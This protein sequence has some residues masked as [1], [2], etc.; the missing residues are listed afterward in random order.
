MEWS[1]LEGVPI[2]ER[3][4]VLANARRR[5]FRYNEVIFHEGDLADTVHLIAKGRVAIQ[6]TTQL[7]DVAILRVLGAGAAFGELALLS[8]DSHRT[9]SAVA[10]ETTE[11]LAIHREVFATLRR[12]HPS[13][14]SWLIDHLAAEVVRLSAEQLEAYYVPAPM[15]VLRRL[16]DM[17][18]LYGGCRCGTVVRLRQEDL[19]TLA[20]ASRAQV[21][22]TLRSAE[23]NGWLTLGRGK[24]EILDASNLQRHCR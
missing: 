16:V 11:T 15:R 13:V 21:N 22:R 17:A 4:V 1:L 23:V 8:P 7:G 14:E 12:A 24:I 6:V 5:R 20:G 18:E 3:R 19:A 10:L 2:D 9:A